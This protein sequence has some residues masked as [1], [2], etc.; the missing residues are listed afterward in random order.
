M[1]IRVIDVEC[2]GLD[3]AIHRICEIATVDLRIM[4]VAKPVNNMIERGRMWS[5][6][7]NP[8][9][10]IPPESSAIHD[11][12][13]DM[14]KDAPTIGDMLAMITDGGL[15][16]YCAHN[17]RYDQ[18]FINPK[19]SVWLDTYRIALWLWPSAPSHSNACLRYWLKLKLAGEQRE[20]VPRWSA[21]CALW[22]AYVTAAILRRAFMDGATIEQMVDVSSQSALLP[23]LYFGKYA[24]KPIGEVDASY[25]DWLLTQQGMDDDIKHTAFAELQRRRNLSKLG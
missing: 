19:D 8:Q 9:M 23:R 21:H 24:G 13:D 15:D 11:I 2:T 18:R 6:L 20:I 1:L 10:P 16:Y 14:V 12:T 25:L 3:P 22:D 7:I 17:S 5:S 4:P